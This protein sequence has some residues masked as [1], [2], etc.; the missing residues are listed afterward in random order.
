MSALPLRTDHFQGWRLGPVLTPSG[1]RRRRMNGGGRS[2]KRIPAHHAD[3][4][5]WLSSSSMT[6]TLSDSIFGKMSPLLAAKPT[7]RPRA[8]PTARADCS[9][10]FPDTL[11]I[12]VI[13]HPGAATLS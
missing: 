4:D 1:H 9:R 13:A 12:Y 5:A 3:G 2:P 10:Y 8:A 7:E 6:K 11:K